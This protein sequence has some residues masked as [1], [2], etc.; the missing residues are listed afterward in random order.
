M[1]EPHKER[2]ICKGIVFC[3]LHDQYRLLVVMHLISFNARLW[4]LFCKLKDI[5][6]VE[7]QSR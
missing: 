4:P 7:I 6:K 5:K 3:S 1:S 2:D